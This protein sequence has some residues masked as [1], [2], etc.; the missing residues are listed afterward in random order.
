MHRNP[1]PL[2]QGRYPLL[3]PFEV[4]QQLAFVVDVAGRRV[5]A[6]WLRDALPLPSDEARLEATVE[7]LDLDTLPA[8]VC[9]CWPDRPPEPVRTARQ[10]W[11]QSW[12]RDRAV[13]NLPA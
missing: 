9:W 11:L 2:E 3:L 12:A 8:P 6:P 4:R 5:I 1:P 7:R 10:N 13:Y